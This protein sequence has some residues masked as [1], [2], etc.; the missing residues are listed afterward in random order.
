MGVLEDKETI[1]TDKV[2]RQLDKKAG[3]IAKILRRGNPTII[4]GLNSTIIWIVVSRIVL[5]DLAA[6]AKSRSLSSAAE[7]KK[8]QEANERLL[9][10]VAGAEPKTDDAD[11]V[12][13]VLTER[14][15]KLMQA[16]RN[17]PRFDRAVALK[18][19]ASHRETVGRLAG[20]K[21]LAG[22][23]AAA[24]EAIEGGIGAL[25]GIEFWLAM[26][27]AV[28][29]LGLRTDEAGKGSDFLDFL[30]GI[31]LAFSLWALTTQCQ[32][33]RLRS[34]H[35]SLSDES[36]QKQAQNDLLK[37]FQVVLRTARA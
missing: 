31:R 26:L 24:T 9:A 19:W 29:A 12:Q 3:D 30:D 18:V 4:A 16:Y 2:L 33:Y 28:G 34:Q 14:A 22:L 6:A 7:S 21:D 10:T 1:A 36:L 5:E 11:K 17:V 35:S 20:A 13:K 37:K 27:K 15:V 25:L 32:I 23:K 8:L